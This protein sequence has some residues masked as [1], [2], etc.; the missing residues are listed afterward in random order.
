MGSKGSGV[1]L[2]NLAE[3]A[4]KK[5]GWPTEVKTGCERFERGMHMR[6]VLL[7]VTRVLFNKLSRDVLDTLQL[8]DHS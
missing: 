4:L 3:A 8:S 7:I 5:A 1:F 6:N 2:I